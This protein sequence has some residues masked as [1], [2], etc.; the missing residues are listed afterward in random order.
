MGQSDAEKEKS[1]LTTVKYSL[2]DLQ[3][4][5]GWVLRH[6]SESVGRRPGSRRMPALW[7]G[8]LRSADGSTWKNSCTS[9]VSLRDSSSSADESSSPDGQTRMYVSSNDL[10]DTS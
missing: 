10:P 9:L 8:G 3:A 6:F 4:E 7:L 2:P 5:H 1:L